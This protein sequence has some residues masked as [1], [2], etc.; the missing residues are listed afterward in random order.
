VAPWVFG[1]A[2]IPFAVLPTEVGGPSSGAILIAGVAGSLALGTGVAVQPAAREFEDTRPLAASTVGLIAAALGFLVGILA[3]D[4]SSR[5]LILLAAPLFGVGYGCCL[6]SGLRESE[7]IAPRIELGATVSVFYA[8]T[9]VGFALPYAIGVLNDWL[10]D[11]GAFAVV[12]ASALVCLVVSTTG[13][14]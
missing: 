4:V 1:C 8:L 6:I 3:L 5:L 9:Y 14:P 7:R 12:G 2:S 13:E 10:G 11:E